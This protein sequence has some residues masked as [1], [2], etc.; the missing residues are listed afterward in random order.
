MEETLNA[1]LDAEANRMC[2][3]ERYEHTEA[4]ATVVAAFQMTSF[5]PVPVYR[6]L[7]PVLFIRDVVEAKQF[8]VEWLTASI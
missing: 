2:R 6:K 3:A 7:P 8:S 5:L 1:M 4:P